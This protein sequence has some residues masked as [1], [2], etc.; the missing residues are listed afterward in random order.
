MSRAYV[1]LTVA[2]LRD[3]VSVGHVLVS[4]SVAAASESEEDEYAAMLGAADASQ[5]WLDGS[6]RRIVAVVSSSTDESVPLSE[7]LAVHA[8]TEDIDADDTDPPE[9]GWFAA[10][11]VTD[12]LANLDA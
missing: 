5:A 7:L 2:Q 10:Q 12:L 8:D 3:A 6:G 4:G 1:P 11:E 9:L